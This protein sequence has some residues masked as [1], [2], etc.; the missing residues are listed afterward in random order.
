[1]IRSN[2]LAFR[3]ANEKNPVTSAVSRV[4]NKGRFKFN[5]SPGKTC[6]QSEPGNQY[7]ARSV[8]RDSGC[9]R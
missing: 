7:L 6:A 4:D 2:P 5:F 9:R 3:R 1:M 8:A